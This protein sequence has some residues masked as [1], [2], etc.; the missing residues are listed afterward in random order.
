MINKTDEKE[1]PGD[2]IT[3]DEHND[4]SFSRSKRDQGGRGQAA[5]DKLALGVVGVAGRKAG[6]RVG[7]RG[8]VAA[9]VVVSQWRL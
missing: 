1:T 6:C 9:G 8:T 4:P 5:G 7:F 3:G 2:D